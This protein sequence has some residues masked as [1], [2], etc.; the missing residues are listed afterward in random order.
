VAEGREGWLRGCRSG[1]GGGGLNGREEV[2][3]VGGVSSG[4]RV[5]E[6]ERAG[7]GGKVGCGAGRGE[8]REWGRR[9]RAAEE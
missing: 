9:G 7:K 5:V 8:R 2:R 3:P 1:G 4:R 6:G